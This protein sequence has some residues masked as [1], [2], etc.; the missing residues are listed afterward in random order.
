[1]SS[2]G[3]LPRPGATDTQ[4]QSRLRHDCNKSFE[5]RVMT[6]T[7]V[8]PPPANL[9]MPKKK[10]KEKKNRLRGIYMVLV[11]RGHKELN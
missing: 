7:V 11:H 3:V 1:M 2:A 9:H 8:L 10:K 4:S 6:S 5:C